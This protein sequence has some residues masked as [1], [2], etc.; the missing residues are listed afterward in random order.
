MT[1]RS[2]DNS[3]WKRV[4]GKIEEYLA[5]K[6][7]PSVSEI[8]GEDRDPFKI[9]ISTMISLRTKDEVTAAAAKRLFGFAR[10]P[11]TL[12]AL[13]ETEIAGAIYPAG[14]YNIKAKN[15]KE[16]SGII[17]GKYGNRVP[18]NIEELLELPGVGRKTANLTISL[19]YGIPAICVDTHVHRISNRTGWVKTKTP[20]QTEQSLM[21]VLPA[22][23][24]I[25]IN[26][27]LVLFGQSLCTPLSPHCGLCPISGD[28]ERR[29]VTR[30]R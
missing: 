10:S 7:L 23:F 13:P 26:E 25:K 6:N 22:E 1:S 19:G 9:L 18:S 28:C 11:E 29:G 17:K 3:Y 16:V 4:L 14:F 30:S 15:I 8:A 2:F 24:W 12:A 27:I 21:T 5:D 20:E